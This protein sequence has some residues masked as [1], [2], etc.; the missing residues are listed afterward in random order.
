MK[1]G[2]A[3]ASRN[4][5]AGSMVAAAVSSAS[6]R[7]VAVVPA[8][9]GSVPLLGSSSSARASAATPAHY[10]SSSLKASL[11]FRPDHNRLTFER[12]AFAGRNRLRTGFRDGG[13]RN[14]FPGR[15]GG[16]EKSRS[17][18]RSTAAQL[19]VE[20]SSRGN[21]QGEENGG[22]KQVIL[23]NGNGAAANGRQV[24]GV[25]YESSNGGNGAATAG[26]GATVSNTNGAAKSSTNG[27]AMGSNG[28]SNAA[29]ELKDSVA[30]KNGKFVAEL[31]ADKIESGPAF[32]TE[33]SSGKVEVIGQEDP[34]FKQGNRQNVK[35]HLV[36]L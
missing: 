15:V 11:L 3:A 32:Q 28:S 29:V 35:V 2:A 17:R 4:H 19:T 26:N 23:E 13:A 12:R 8:G 21:G 1:G 34:W 6:C 9:L 14:I 36:I 22:F 16:T 5:T 33:V 27:A 25:A 18:R 24:N 7:G 20:Q 30:E 10:S 31:V